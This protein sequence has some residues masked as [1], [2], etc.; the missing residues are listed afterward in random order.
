M[1]AQRYLQGGHT[2][3]PRRQ[4]HVALHWHESAVHCPPQRHSSPHEQAL[5]T[6]WADMVLFVLVPHKKL[7][8]WPDMH[9]IIY[10]V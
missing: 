9:P 2:A 1:R 8:T 5:R 4:L 10:T 7:A 3:L 6:V